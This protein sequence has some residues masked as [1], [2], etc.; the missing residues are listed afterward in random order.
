MFLSYLFCTLSY[1]IL[2]CILTQGRK[3]RLIINYASHSHA[4][5]NESICRYKELLHNFPIFH[6]VGDGIMHEVM[7]NL[8]KHFV[9]PS[10]AIVTKNDIGK[11]T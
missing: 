4:H 2:D 7:R 11:M 3:V 8:Q 6:D 10:E 9:R 1:T 5:A